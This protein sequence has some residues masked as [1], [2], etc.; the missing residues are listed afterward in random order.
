[1]KYFSKLSESVKPKKAAVKKAEAKAAPKKVAKK[2]VA[3]KKRLKESE[4][5]SR[6]L[7][8]LIESAMTETL[9]NIVTESALPINDKHA[10]VNLIEKASY[11]EDEMLGFLN[12]TVDPIISLVGNYDGN[13][14]FES[15]NINKT[16]AV[17]MA[18]Y[19]TAL[20]LESA[21]MGALTRNSL[22]RG[23]AISEDADP[24]MSEV[25][26]VAN[27]DE[28]AKK[29]LEDVNPTPDSG[30]VFPTPQENVKG[31]PASDAGVNFA[32]EES[33]HFAQLL[34]LSQ[35][36]LMDVHQ[37]EDN[38]MPTLDNPG[39]TTNT[40]GDPDTE[41]N[42]ASDAAIKSF[43]GETAGD[44]DNGLFE[45]VVESA[46][47]RLARIM[48]GL[49]E[50]AKPDSG[51]DQDVYTPTSDKNIMTYDGQPAGEPGPGENA[52]GEFE[53][54]GSGADA[55]VEAQI[56]IAKQILGK[57]FKEYGINEKDAQKTVVREAVRSLFKYGIDNLYPSYSDAAQVVT[58]QNK[59]SEMYENKVA[60][61]KTIIESTNPVLTENLKNGL[62]AKSK[63]L[64]EA[65]QVANI[66]ASKGNLREAAK[67]RHSVAY[68][69]K[70][71]D[72]ERTRQM[73]RNRMS[74]FNEAVLNKLTSGYVIQENTSETA[75]QTR[76]AITVRNYVCE[77]DDLKEYFTKI[78]KESSPIYNV[79]IKKKSLNNDSLVTAALM[80]EC[81]CAWNKIKKNYYNGQPK[82]VRKIALESILNVIPAYK[83]MS[84]AI[85]NPKALQSVLE[86]FE[87]RIQSLKDKLTL[88]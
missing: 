64:L 39:N 27:V 34:E 24:T 43:E 13:R 16:K 53:A 2:A 22:K 30:D 69:T 83:H 86:S 78:L 51:T 20:T 72:L 44:P 23:L 15:K 57:I 80:T 14:I 45:P 50:G 41:A 25:I 40:L 71:A 3:E 76:D 5:T 9:K 58:E 60:D 74:H 52:A 61:A 65:L 12:E 19:E 84:G 42:F 6:E 46:G 11:N 54:G 66:L 56:R 48:Y 31:D 47:A 70:A 21:R 29:S 77:H 1:M 82:E 4:I 33:Y 10:S 38:N 32:V 55:I 26:S 75:I 63:Q 79:S 18:V 8:S 68:I 49:N 88:I 59:L 35:E 36:E 87:Y 7:D 67:I 37:Y 62:I 28:D 73:F 85:K 17:N 81:V